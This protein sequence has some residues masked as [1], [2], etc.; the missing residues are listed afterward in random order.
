MVAMRRNL[1]GLLLWV[2]RM[3]SLVPHSLHHARPQDTRAKYEELLKQNAANDN[4][5]GKKRSVVDK[6]QEQASSCSRRRELVEVQ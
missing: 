4:K 2:E 3:H 1:Q 5:D 6:L